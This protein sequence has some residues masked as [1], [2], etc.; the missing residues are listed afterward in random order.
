MNRQNIVFAIFGDDKFIS[1]TYGMFTQLVKYPKLYGNSQGQIATCQSNFRSKMKS[2]F[3]AKEPEEFVDSD[4]IDKKI[5]GTGVLKLVDHLVD[6]ST[7]KDILDNYKEFS[8]RCFEIDLDYGAHNN[9]KYPT[10]EE[11]D[12]AL[13]KIDLTAPINTYNYDR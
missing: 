7:P 12:I 1:W 10:N 9:W 5:T 6:A 11:F 8:F 2:Y 4:F 13:S 3:E